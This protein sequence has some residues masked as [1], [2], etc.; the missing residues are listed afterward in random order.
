MCRSSSHVK[1]DCISRLLATQIQNSA[2]SET[3]SRSSQSS[4]LRREHCSCISILP[5]CV[6]LCLLPTPPLLQA[7]NHKNA[8][9]AAP[10]TTEI[11]TLS[12][13]SHLYVVGFNLPCA[14]QHLIRRI[15]QR[16]IH[17]EKST[18]HDFLDLAVIRVA[19]QD[20]R[21]DSETQHC[22]SALLENQN[23]ANVSRS[24]PGTC[25]LKTVVGMR[26]SLDAQNIVS[27][28]W[29]KGWRRSTGR[30]FWAK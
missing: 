1:T 12:Q 11:A 21:T 29:K 16:Q 17:G 26:K 5:Q 30:L 7:Y 18:P 23:V 28:Y 10:A 3:I 20:V 22:A 15:I 9:L 4:T 6:P 8:T 25:E 19:Q 2:T 27:I 13:S 14:P 24:G